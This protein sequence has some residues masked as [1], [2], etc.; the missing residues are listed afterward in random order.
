LALSLAACQTGTQPKTL[1]EIH[2]AQKWPRTSGAELNGS[3]RKDVKRFLMGMARE[4]VTAAAEAD[5]Y[6]CTYG[7]GHDDYPELTAQCTKRLA[8]RACQM[9]WNIRLTSDQ[10]KPGKVDD[11]DRS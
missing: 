11:V 2:Q 5:V 1:A 8:T 10:K 9:E 6:K 4:D 7:E 3:F